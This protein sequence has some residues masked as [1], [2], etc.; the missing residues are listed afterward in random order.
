MA[1]VV[2]PELLLKQHF[3]K[4]PSSPSPE[5]VALQGKRLIW[6]SETSEGREFDVGRVKWLVGGEKLT[7]RG[8]YAKNQMTF[9]LLHNT[10]IIG[11]INH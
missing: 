8:L 2:V 6:A 3:S 5:I 1:G 4:N 10:M 7:G 9:A 11:Y